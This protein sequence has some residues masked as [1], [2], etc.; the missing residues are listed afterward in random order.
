MTPGRSLALAWIF[1][2]LS[3]SAP[4]VSQTPVGGEIDIAD[5]DLHPKDCPRT[6]MAADGRFVVFWQATLE[7][8]PPG[9]DTLQYRLFDRDG[10]ARTPVQVASSRPVFSPATP[11]VGMADD[12]SFVATWQVVLPSSNRS[13]VV[14]R[15]FD[16]Q[17]RPRGRE[18]RVHADASLQQFLPDIAV[19]PNGSFGIIWTAQSAS[20]PVLPTAAVA[21]FYDSDGRPLG[22]AQNVLSGTA[23]SSFSPRIAASRDARF[24][25]VW[26]ASTANET[27]IYGLR[28]SNR[29]VAVGGIVAI[30]H[31]VN[32]LK[33]NPSVAFSTDGT[34][35]AVSWTDL[36]ADPTTSTTSTLTSATP[37][38]SD[39]KLIPPPNSDPLGVVAQV[40]TSRFRPTAPP[41]RVNTFLQGGQ[42]HSSIAAARDD[43]WLV[44]WE[45][46]GNQDGDGPGILSRTFDAPASGTPELV[47]NETTAGP[48]NCPAM[49]TAPS[50][51]GIVVWTSFDFGAQGQRLLARLLADE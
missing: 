26:N 16:A 29:G 24:A 21:R 35:V 14:A 50:G 3:F 4:V 34:K 11:A 6:A 2:G 20:P 10:V 5:G 22:A 43:S 38:S 8:T 46:S 27:V 32:H 51:R 19:A 30:A 40:F 45:S 13:Y 44:A 15:R 48:Q 17:G 9:R 39:N 31:D 1:F 25:A 12:G 7:S 42:E 23:V 47:I 33:L 18:F 36:Q 28:Y 37:N 49:A 41:F